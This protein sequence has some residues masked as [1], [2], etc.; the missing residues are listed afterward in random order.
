MS[1]SEK[2]MQ[3]QQISAQPTQKNRAFI[4]PE[5]R[6]AEAAL[7]SNVVI[8]PAKSLLEVCAHLSGHTQI[9]SYQP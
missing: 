1:Q 9:T 6:A 7:V 8:L 4:L 5:E 3:A 2:I